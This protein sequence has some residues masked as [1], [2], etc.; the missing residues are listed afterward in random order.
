MN[1][2]KFPYGI[3]A[4]SLNFENFRETLQ[5]WY[6]VQRPS[7]ESCEVKVNVNRTLKGLIDWGFT[8]FSTICQSYHGGQFTYTCVSW[9]PHTS[10][11]HN[12][13]LKQ[14]AAFP[15]RL[16]AHWWKTNV[17]KRKAGRKT[18]NHKHG[19]YYYKADLK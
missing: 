19:I 8:P 7:E 10:K 5:A 3:A 13:L 6:I 9:L 18:F 14:L 11:P 15:H 17:T 12:K 2:S 1:A 16:F 4:F